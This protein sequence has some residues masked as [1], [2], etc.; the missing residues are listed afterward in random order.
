MGGLVVSAL[1]NAGISYFAS[2][3]PNITQRQSL[4]SAGIGLGLTVGS[5]LLNRW[6]RD[7]ESN[8]TFV[9]AIK[10]RERIISNSV[11]P[12]SYIIGTTKTS[13]ALINRSE[14]RPGARVADDGVVIPTR[15]AVLR[16][17][18]A[19]SELNISSIEQIYI[20][21][22]KMPFVEDITGAI[23]PDLSSF[24][25]EIAELQA[26]LVNLG[27]VVMDGII[28]PDDDDSGGQ[29]LDLLNKISE[30]EKERDN[31]KWF[32]R[33]GN[34]EVP[35]VRI[36]VDYGGNNQSVADIRAGQILNSPWGNPN[37]LQEL[38]WALVELRSLSK[39]GP[40]WSNNPNIQF[41]IKG[42][43]N[44]SYSENPA[45]IAEWLCK[46]FYGLLD[47]DLS[48]VEEAKRICNTNIITQEVGLNDAD[49]T[50]LN[51]VRKILFPEAFDDNGNLIPANLPN[52][53]IQTSAI[54]EWNIKYAGVGNA[55]K[56]YQAH[57]VITTSMLLQ[58]LTLLK[59][60]GFAM[61]GW[62]VPVGHQIKFVPGFATIP[63]KTI[64]QDDLVSEITQELGPVYEKRYSAIKGQIAQLK[65]E[66]FTSF[67]ID[68]VVDVDLVNQ[69]GYKEEN[70]GVLPFQNSEVAARR[71]LAKYRRR[72]HPD[73]KRLKFAVNRGGPSWSN[74]DL[75]AGDRIILNIPIEDLDNEIYRIVTVGANLDATVSLEVIEEPDSVW[76]DSFDPSIEGVTG[77]SADDANNPSS[78]FIFARA[79]WRRLSIKDE[80]TTITKFTPTDDMPMMGEENTP[81]QAIA[82]NPNYNQGPYS[83]ESAPLDDDIAADIDPENDD[84]PTADPPEGTT[85]T[86][87]TKYLLDI[88]IDFGEEVKSLRITSKE[89]GGAVV[90]YNSNL[91]IVDINNGTVVRT[92]LDAMG[93]LIIYNPDSIKEV[94]VE[95]IGFSELDQMGMQSDKY[96]IFAGVPGNIS[97]GDLSDY[98]SGAKIPESGDSLRQ[99]AD[100]KW[101]PSPSALVL[102][103]IPEDVTDYLPGTVLGKEEVV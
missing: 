92:M 14:Y 73:R 90:T 102:E 87:S 69:D 82:Q 65:T 66:D 72:N 17:I 103:E 100:G 96:R 77:K 47:E 55:E 91:S 60:L 71:L 50:M 56:R 81:S 32:T 63:V 52:V 18:I 94:T 59:Q 49:P 89:T 30:L 24:D 23:F 35:N 70:I 41:V 80:Y 34:T 98:A 44:G 21:G 42:E 43:I 2:R 6:L 39:D 85:G 15:Y 75:E 16:R 45:A 27:C 86:F 22:R 3:G 40:T 12:V 31:T 78:L 28:D 13:G 33:I 37:Q 64:T 1:V 62:F 48:G 97:L 54:N 7:D 5:Y 95:I 8:E 101:L 68:P 74:F 11:V 46:T 4:T 83:G 20:D 58:P 10:R 67:S 36:Y 99:N 57:G 25:T 9:N 38:S 88:A 19:L 53:G 29:C 26:R 84:E 76:E 93:V 61:G 79:S 51:Q